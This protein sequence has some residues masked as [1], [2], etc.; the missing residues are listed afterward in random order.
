MDQLGGEF[1]FENRPA[2]QPMSCAWASRMTTTRDHVHPK[3]LCQR[4]IRFGP[5]PVVKIKEELAEENRMEM[6]DLQTPTEASCQI[7][8]LP[9]QAKQ[10][11]ALQV[12]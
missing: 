1:I 2:G 12:G 5:D 6:L 4:A 3:V 10:Q 8:G 11:E 7:A 9:A